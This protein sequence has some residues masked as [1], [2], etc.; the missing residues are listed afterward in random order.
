M[1]LDGGGSPWTLRTLDSD[2]DDDSAKESLIRWY[3]SRGYVEAGPCDHLEK[4]L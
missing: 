2:L 4:E 1:K 3:K